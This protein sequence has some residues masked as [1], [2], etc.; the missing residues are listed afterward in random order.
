VTVDQYVGG[1][2]KI[3][4]VIVPPVELAQKALGSS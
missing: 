2:S 3:I 4:T 1:Q